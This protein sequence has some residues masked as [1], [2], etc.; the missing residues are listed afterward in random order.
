MKIPL[1]CFIPL[2]F[3]TIESVEDGWKTIRKIHKTENVLNRL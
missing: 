3:R 2:K 1:N